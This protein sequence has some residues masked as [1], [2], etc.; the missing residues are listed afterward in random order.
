VVFH[1]SSSLK[2]YA[3]IRIARGYRLQDDGSVP[4]WDN[5]ISSAQSSEEHWYRYKEYKY[6]LP[7]G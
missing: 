6:L 3:I 5:S 4:Y 1:K 7:Q 2:L